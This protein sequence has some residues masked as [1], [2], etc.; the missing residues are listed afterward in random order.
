MKFLTVGQSCNIGFLIIACSATV[1]KH[2]FVV[3]GKCNHTADNE[4]VVWTYNAESGG[5]SNGHYITRATD[6]IVKL[7]HAMSV[8]YT[9]MVERSRC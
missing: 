9:R 1:D 5:Y 6:E 2:L 4:Y 3:L 7:E 8:F